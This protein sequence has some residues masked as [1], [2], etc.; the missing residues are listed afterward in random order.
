MIHFQKTLAGLAFVGVVG[1]VARSATAAPL[2][3]ET[4]PTDALVTL[5][6]IVM[7]K[8]PGKAF[9][10]SLIPSGLPKAGLSTEGFDAD[11]TIADVLAWVKQEARGEDI[12][13]LLKD[14]KSSIK[15]INDAKEY[16]G[17]GDPT[18]LTEADFTLGNGY[19]AKIRARDY[20]NIRGL[21]QMIALVAYVNG[22]MILDDLVKVDPDLRMKAYAIQAERAVEAKPVA[23]PVVKAEEPAPSTAIASNPQPVP[24]QQEPEPATPAVNDTTPPEDPA[25]QAPIDGAAAV[26]NPP[27]QT[28]GHFPWKFIFI[29]LGLV[30]GTF[31]AAFGIRAAVRSNRR[32]NAV[33]KSLVAGDGHGKT[34]FEQDIAARRAE[35]KR[36]QNLQGRERLKDKDLRNKIKVVQA[37]GRA[38]LEHLVQAAEKTGDADAKRSSSVRL[39]S[40][41]PSSK[42][43]PAHYT[44]SQLKGIVARAEKAEA[45]GNKGKKAT[46]P[47]KQM[48]FTFYDEDRHP[49]TRQLDLPA[50]SRLLNKE[51]SDELLPKT[52]SELE[53]HLD[54]AANLIKE[55]R[56]YWEHK[57]LTSNTEFVR[58]TLRLDD[59]ITQRSSRTQVV[60]FKKT[61]PNDTVTL[62]L[63]KGPVQKTLNQCAA[64]LASWLSDAE[65]STK[66]NLQ[67]YLGTV[68]QLLDVMEGHW[69]ARTL[70]SHAGYVAQRE[71]LQGLR[72]GTIVPKTT[73]AAA[74]PA[75]V[76]AAPAAASTPL[77]DDPKKVHTFYIP[78]GHSYKTEGNYD[79]DLYGLSGLIEMAISA[80]NENIAK[81]LLEDGLKYWSAQ[82]IA[83]HDADTQN[84]GI[85]LADLVARFFPAD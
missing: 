39:E 33:A 78:A 15:G 11:P 46:D 53:H 26:N 36:L 74:A 67:G 12:K 21:I 38:Y 10:G 75:P 83:T 59:I 30:A 29:S 14:L 52:E 69:S 79:D 49:T 42:L 62:T 4:S 76:V 28:P 82:A 19:T 51:L 66:H 55:A 68:K 27:T 22:K 3:P 50:L 20:K 70:N 8:N 2:G 47:N 6:E 45:S 25:A 9:V 60:D 80:G 1:G 13:D 61:D 41:N 34:A 54:D 18:L 7:G 35:I 31:G 24:A 40:F 44:L 72:K 77:S 43:D 81:A 63:S 17:D 37:G 84:I 64:D 57:V 16:D 5:K 23:R 71:R 58:A 73:A 85:T 56:G 65:L 48:S 32:K